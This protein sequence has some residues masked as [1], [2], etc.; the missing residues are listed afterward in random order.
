MSDDNVIHF[1]PWQDFNDVSAIVDP[2]DIEPDVEQ[3]KIFAAQAAIV[4]QNARL[5]REIADRG[6]PRDSK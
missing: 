1:N 2:A 5:R 3:L 4:M 6:R